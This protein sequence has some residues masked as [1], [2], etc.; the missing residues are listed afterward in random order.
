MSQSDRNHY[1]YNP[2]KRAIEER[3]SPIANLTSILERR[4]YRNEHRWC[5]QTKRGSSAQT[6]VGAF[7]ANDSWRNYQ[8]MVIGRRR[9]TIQVA[10]LHNTRRAL[11][12]EDLNS[13]PVEYTRYVMSNI[14]LSKVFSFGTARGY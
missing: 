7:F 1:L 5:L 9:R 4:L 3:A 6:S 8:E 13:C 10:E 11:E 2:R 12:G 14:Q